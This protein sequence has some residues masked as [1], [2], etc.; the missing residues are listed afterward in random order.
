MAG[1]VAARG[2]DAVEAAALEVLGYPAP[3]VTA[4]KEFL[5]IRT[6][7]TQGAA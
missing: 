1:L 5:T 2:R 6:F 7:L 3:W 4:V